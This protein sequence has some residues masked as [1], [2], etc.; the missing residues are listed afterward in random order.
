MSHKSDWVSYLISVFYVLILVGCLL[1]IRKNMMKKRNLVQSNEYLK[2]RR[3]V[4][5]RYR[6]YWFLFAAASVRIASLIAA[7][8]MGKTMIIW[9]DTTE[10]EFF[11]SLIGS[12]AS[13][14]FY[15]AFTF[16]IWFFAHLAFHAEP[17]KKKLITPFFTGINVILYISSFSFGS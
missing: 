11:W 4:V 7:V 9:K 12:I 15:T 10:E 5:W 14:L 13:N 3:V 17:K 2:Q 1:G 6:F 16:I 8:I